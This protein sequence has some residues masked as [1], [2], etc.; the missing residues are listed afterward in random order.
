MWGG[1][2]RNGSQEEVPLWR[3]YCMGSCG[4]GPVDVW[5]LVIKFWRKHV[6]S[7]GEVEVILSDFWVLVLDITFLE[8]EG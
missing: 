3:E 6:Y 1:L 5:V 8:S 2:G 4:P 7:C